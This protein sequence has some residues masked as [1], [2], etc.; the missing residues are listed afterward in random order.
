MTQAPSPNSIFAT[1]TQLLDQVPNSSGPFSMTEFTEPTFEA[2][3]V[4]IGI[5]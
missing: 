1:S 2:I 4:I 3:Q 5:F